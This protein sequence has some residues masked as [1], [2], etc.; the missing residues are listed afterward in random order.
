[1]MEQ[2]RIERQFFAKLVR[3]ARYAIQSGQTR[4][5]IVRFSIDQQ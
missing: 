2:A 1:M 3:T 5:V 4:S